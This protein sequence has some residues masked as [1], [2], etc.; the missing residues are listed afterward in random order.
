MMCLVRITA[1]GLGLCDGGASEYECSALAQK[2]NSSKNVQLTTSA[3]LLQ[4]LC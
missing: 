2:P 4:N 3:Q 1:N